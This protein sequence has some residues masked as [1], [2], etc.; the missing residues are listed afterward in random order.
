MFFKENSDYCRKN[1]NDESVIYKY[2]RQLI[3]YI[4][5][6]IMNDPEIVEKTNKNQPQEQRHLDISL[7]GTASPA[8]SI[9]SWLVQLLYSA[10]RKNPVILQ[11]YYTLIRSA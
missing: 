3:T 10:I 2:S 6:L 5:S 8:D 9:T 1:K 7:T 11:F 4:V